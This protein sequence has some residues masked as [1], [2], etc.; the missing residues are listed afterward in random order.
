M[1]VE[2]ETNYVVYSGDDVADTFPFTFPVYDEEHFF[3][4]LQDTTTEELTLLVASAYSV[5]GI[6]EET[7]GSVITDDPVASTDR[8]LL[9][10]IVPLTQDLDILNQ[11]GFHPRNIERQFDLVAMQIQQLSEETGRTVRAP[12][13]EEFDPLPPPPER[14]G[15]LLGFT[16]DADAVPTLDTSALLFTLLSGLLA[17]GPGIDITVGGNT[18][19]IT[20]SAPAEDSW[21]LE[22]GTSGGGGGAADPET[23]RDIIGT[24][25]QGLGLDIVVD[26]ALNTITVDMTGAVSAEVIR[27]RIG[28]TLIEGDGITLNPDDPSD[29]LE[30]AADPA[31]ILSTVN[32]NPAAP[33]IQSVASSATVTPTFLNDQVNITALATNLTLANPTGTAVHGHGIVIRIKDNGTART[34]SYGTK[35]RAVG[36]TKPITT[37]IGKTLYIGMIYNLTDDKWDVFPSQQ[38]V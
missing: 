19:T 2:T 12:L 32:A 24:A 34:I 30:I 5:T 14:R 22:S 27:D 16:D 13:G 7:G 33:R 8:I 15:N 25:L 18:I 36:T 28:A 23:V 21:L 17:E 11:S 31:F 10:R 9:A 29:T 37:T 20:N 4:Y 6:G 3:V 35:Y 38:E 1:T 26:D